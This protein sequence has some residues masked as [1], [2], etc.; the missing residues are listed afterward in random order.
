MRK[1]I[2]E[3][4]REYTGIWFVSNAKNMVEAKFGL[5][6]SSFVKTVYSC[7]KISHR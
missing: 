2:M 5:M 1:Q 4:S 7:G 3:T 6:A